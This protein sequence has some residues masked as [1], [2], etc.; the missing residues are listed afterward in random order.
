MESHMV[1]MGEEGAS[2]E[3]LAVTKDITKERENEIALRER[4]GRIEEIE[5]RL[6]QAQKMEALGTMAGGIARDFN[7]LLLT[8][9]GNVEM[10]RIYA[11]DNGAVI[12]RLNLSLKA[13]A[14]A[15]D[16]VR[17]ILNFGERPES[18]LF[19]SSES[20]PVTANASST[21]AVGVESVRSAASGEAPHGNGEAI[22][23]VDDEQALCRLVEVTLRRCGYHGITTVDPEEAIALFRAQPQ[24]FGAVISDYTMPKMTG[25]TL[26]EKIKQ[27][28]P[29]M[30]VILTTGV[31]SEYDPELLK[32]QFVDAVISKPFTMQA[33]AA[34]LAKWI[35]ASRSNL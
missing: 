16:L 27:I 15:G 9:I 14:R 21:A 7:N 35:A 23:Y 11:Q 30:P 22:L 28:A 6:R 5:T 18:D 10:A 13:A 2:A 31:T 24:R 12:D 3:V 20:A 29:R 34:A 1:A 17:Q 4:E 26:A 19:V 32:S 25:L 33:L 8:I